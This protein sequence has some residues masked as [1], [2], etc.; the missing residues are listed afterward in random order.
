M[1]T[2]TKLSMAVAGA[3]AIALAIPA[4]LATTTTVP[5]VRTPS[6]W[7]HPVVQRPTTAA[8][9]AS[10]T[11]TA[12]QSRG[13]VLIE[14]TTLSGGGAGTGMVLTASGQVLTN[15]HVV[16]GSTSLTATVAD[17]GKQYA[18]TVVGWD[19]EQDVALLQ[20]QDASGLAT[21]TLD[22]DDLAVGDALT[23]VGNA[24]GGGALVAASGRVTAL[25]QQVTVSNEGRAETLT[26]AIQTD[27]GAEP[28]DSGGPMFD[29]EGEVAG[30]TTAGGQTTTAVPGRRG[31]ALTATSVSYAVPIED[32]MGVIDQI[33]AGHEAGTVRI[34]PRAYLGISVGSQSLVVASVVEG[35]P[36]ATAGLQAGSVI[37]S[38]G[39]SAVTT[40]DELSAALDALEPDQAVSVTWTDAGGVRHTATVTLGSSPVA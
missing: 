18:A 14:S 13:V 19:A 36:A 4:P 22:D 6:S 21:V 12:A 9:S 30:M 40:H 15:Y 28:G 24:E 25:N 8:A 20:L 31:P 17:T 39:G 11:P 29:D 10:T 38:I 7:T 35:G 1:K 34:G 5:V 33:R 3:C 2:S 37:T 23:A 32:A 16:E 27:A 26:G